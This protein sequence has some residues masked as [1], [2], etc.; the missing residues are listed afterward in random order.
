MSRSCDVDR[1]VTDIADKNS[2]RRRRANFKFAPL[3]H[4]L[5]SNAI[6][7]WRFGDDMSPLSNANEKDYETINIRSEGV[8]HNINFTYLTI[9][10]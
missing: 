9:I 6:K 3:A 10:E 5:L 1:A 7:T 8:K 4:S 2:L